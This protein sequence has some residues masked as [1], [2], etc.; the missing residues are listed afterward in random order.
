MIERE[1]QEKV[2]VAKKAEQQAEEA[3]VMVGVAEQKALR[4]KAEAE[5]KVMYPT[6]TPAE[7]ISTTSGG[8][9]QGPESIT[10]VAEVLILT[11]AH[12]NRGPTR[13]AGDRGARASEAGGDRSRRTLQGHPRNRQE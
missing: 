5:G 13:T 9:G 2:V 12:L 8:R 6:C 1:N 3:R 10:D 11:L 7:D 4:M